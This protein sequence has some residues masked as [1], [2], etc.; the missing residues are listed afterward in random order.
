MFVRPAVPEDLPALEALYARARAFM[1]EQGNHTQWGE[2]YPLAVQMEEVAADIALGRSFVCMDGEKIAG[3]FMLAAGPDPTYARIEGGGWP[4]DEP[5]GVVHRV[6]TGGTRNGAGEFCLNWCMERYA[7]LRIDTHADNRPMLALLE[8]L[9]F[10]YCGVIYVEDGTPRRA[11]CRK[12][13][14]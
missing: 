4:D 8:K 14:G 1:R 2:S 13:G 10:A 6:A 11:Y 3:V 5:Y 9:G 7:T 12:R